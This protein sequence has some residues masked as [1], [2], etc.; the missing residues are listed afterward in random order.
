MTDYTMPTGRYC[1]SGEYVIIPAGV[2]GWD[3]VRIAVIVAVLVSAPWAWMLNDE[4]A[5]HQQLLAEAV[6]RQARVERLTIYYQ[7]GVKANVNIKESQ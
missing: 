7:G 5:T 1:R 2:H 4:R 3:L 6:A